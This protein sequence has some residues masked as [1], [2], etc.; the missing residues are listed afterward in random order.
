MR[1][2]VRK[3]SSCTEPE[4]KTEGQEEQYKKVEQEEW[5]QRGEMTKGKATLAGKGQRCQRQPRNLCKA[6]VPQLEQQEERKVTTKGKATHTK[7][8]GNTGKVNL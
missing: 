3:Y 8:E 6:R 7:H 5:G 4:V 1:M 2:N